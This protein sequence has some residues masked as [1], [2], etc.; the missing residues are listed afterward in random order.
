MQC[1]STSCSGKPYD[2]LRDPLGLPYQ[3]FGV[4]LRQHLLLIG[5]LVTVETNPTT[6]A[7]LNAAWPLA[8]DPR[9]EGA[10]HIRNIKTVLQ[11][12]FPNLS[13]SVSVSDA[14]LNA[15]AAQF[16]SDGKTFTPG[17]A[18]LVPSPTDTSKHD[19]QRVV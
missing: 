7:A 13:G 16:S 6:I 18:Y 19:P 17:T 9:F 5:Y 14:T 15:I 2:T 12:T 11:D 8:T 1:E 10:A 3:S 4:W